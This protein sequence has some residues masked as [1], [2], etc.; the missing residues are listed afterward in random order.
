MVIIMEKKNIVLTLSLLIIV[1]FSGCIAQI[2]GNETLS[3][4]DQIRKD[5]YSN[6]TLMFEMKLPEGWK[7]DDDWE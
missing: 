3:N 4:T 1:I 7:S 5:V 6:K 2:A